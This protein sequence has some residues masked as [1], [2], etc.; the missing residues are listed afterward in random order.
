MFDTPVALIVFRRPE[1]T[2]RVLQSIAR[3]QPQ[4]LL[5][6]ADG[7]RPDHPGDIEACHATRAVVDRLD[8]DC[9]ILKNYSGVNLG[10]GRGP[11]TGIDWVFSQVPEAIILEDDCL[12]HPSFFRFCQELLER[13]RDDE[14]VMHIGGSTYQ[15]GT[16]PVPYS[17]FFSCFNGAWGWATWR[18]AWQHFDLS[19]KQWALL[20][21]T[22]WLHDLLEDDAAVA[23]WT[24]EF[25][26][27]YER[28]GDVSY[29]DHQWTFA[30]WANS[31]LSI[32]PRLNLV[33][34]IGCCA[35]AT[36]TFSEDDVRANLPAED[37][38]F[39]L[40]HP[41]MVLQN[42]AMD[43][44]FIKEL[45]LP[46]LGHR[47]AP[48]LRRVGSRWTPEFVKAALRPLASNSGARA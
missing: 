23:H 7:P 22:S 40:L 48:W 29:W 10:C 9:Q 8:W 38:G 5:V 32:R 17:Y 46:H 15:R 43:R 30:C 24:K 37:I 27:A 3:V 13:Y 44:A 35:D 2:E 25:E 28:K 45:I 42:R 41:P 20:R 14:R 1:F 21:D 33:S 47:P 6:F 26:G 4:T 18:R 39:P 12:P 36:H 19:V 16:L 31:G 11:A 34:N